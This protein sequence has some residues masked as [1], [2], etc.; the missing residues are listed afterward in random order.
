MAYS[1]VKG[2][3]NDL[4]AGQG[5]FY[6]RL[7]QFR[8]YIKGPHFFALYEKSEELYDEITEAMDEVAKRLLITGCWRRTLLYTG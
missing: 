8:W 1:D 4:V 2:Y 5:V 6:T 3:L 7:H